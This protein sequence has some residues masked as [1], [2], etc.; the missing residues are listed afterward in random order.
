MVKHRIKYFNRHPGYP[1]ADL[2]MWECERCGFAPFKPCVVAT[3]EINEPGFRVISEPLNHR[4]ARFIVV[5]L[6]VLYNQAIYYLLP[7]QDF[8]KFR[9]GTAK[10]TVID[11]EHDRSC[12][13]PL[14]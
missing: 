3:G 14:N 4:K 1:A 12:H 7:Y 8:L 6:N 9:Y 5:A 11:F 13:E 2:T 10:G